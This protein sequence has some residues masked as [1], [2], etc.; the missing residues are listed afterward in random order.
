MPIKTP[1]IVHRGGDADREIEQKVEQMFYALDQQI[2]QLSQTRDL[3]AA[4]IRYLRPLHCNVFV[5]DEKIFVTLAIHNIGETSI[6]QVLD[7]SGKEMDLPSAIFLVERDLGFEN[8]FG[9]EFM[10]SI[11]DSS[12]RNKEE[13]IS[14]IAEK[15]IDE[16]VVNIEKLARIVKINPVFQRREFLLDEKMVFVLS[17]FEEP[18]DT[19]YSDHIRP[20]IEKIDGFRCL[21]ADDICDNRPIIEDVWQYIN[22]ARML[23]AELTGRNPNV[24]YEVGIAHTV[25]KEVILLT[26]SIEDVPFDLRHLRC[27]V[28][29]D[30]PMGVQNLEDNLKSTIL[31]IR[32]NRP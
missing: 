25:G 16:E 15:C 26:Q 29:E 24:F 1:G 13:E 27:I 31:N 30:T 9:F 5:G 22:E 3:P 19:I 32:S 7:W 21:R 20:A 12:N 6:F 17:P 18:F 28:Y 4:Q 23:V 11:L 8:A 10:R 2:E 14:Q